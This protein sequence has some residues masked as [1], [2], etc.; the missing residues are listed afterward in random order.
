MG[1]IA[2]AALDMV[3][4]NTF[5]KTCMSHL[6]T[7]ASGDSCSQIDF[8]QAQRR[9]YPASVTDAK[10]KKEILSRWHEYFDELL[11]IEFSHLLIPEDLPCCGPV[12]QIVTEV[13]TIAIGSMKNQ[14]ALGPDDLPVDIWKL[15]DLHA[16]TAAWLTVFFNAAIS[17]NQCGFVKGCGTTDM[18]FAACQLME[19]HHEKNSPL[20]TAFLD[21]EKAF[22]HVS[23]QLIWYAL[24][25]H[26][27]PEEHIIWVKLLY[28]NNSSRVRCAAGTSDSFPVN[29]GVHQGSALSP[30][31]FILV[32]DIVTW[33][34][35]GS[36]P[37]CCFIAMTSC[38]QPPPERSCSARCKLGVT[39]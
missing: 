36:V 2:T 1:T 17:V 39:A 32:M 21:L 38:L 37:G 18:I 8:M 28:V 16:E 20:H 30:L 15:K 34:L 3:I 4:C 24:C 10:D 23:H 26:G 22:D 5:F 19:K 35:Q 29:V 27:V 13:V 31:L 11:N 7:Y 25:D 9:D 14:K 12:P 6:V 33:D